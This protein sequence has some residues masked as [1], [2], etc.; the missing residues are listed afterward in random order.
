M[1]FFVHRIFSY[2]PSKPRQPLLRLALGLLGLVLLGVLVVA[3]LFVGVGMLMF[4]ATRRLISRPAKPAPSP[5][6]ES[7]IDGEF[8]V[9]EKNHATLGMS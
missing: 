7:V 9:I 1:P 4:A 3:G 8:S 5:R 6:V 2:T